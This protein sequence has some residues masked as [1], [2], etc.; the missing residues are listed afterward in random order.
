M[1]SLVYD[2]AREEEKMLIK[3]AEKMGV[4]LRLVKIGN[5]VKVESW[6]PDVYLIRTISHNKGVVAAAVV[7]SSGGYS[8]NSSSALFISW[9]KALTIAKL[10]AANLPIPQTSVLFGES[11]I[12]VRDR[13][14]VKTVS[15]SWG[16]KVALVSTEEEL[17]LVMKSSEGEVYIMQE[18]VGTG[19]DIRVFVVGDRAVAAMRRVPPSGDWRSNAARGGSTLPQKIDGEL[20]EL[21]VKATK[22]VG[23]FYAGVDILVGER[24]Y[25]NEVNGI[26][27][28]K[29]LSR[30][31]GVD[32][33]RHILEALVEFRKKG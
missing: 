22:A 12:E 7:E 29:A 14:I 13:A 18:V 10:K 31:T 19:E 30:T 1:V 9:N 25:V 21:A 3:A 4:S 5:V 26:P 15:G 6:D 20:E 28:F 33:A 11:D 24:L 27:E 23:A 32:V 17:K 2:V 16:R 8:I